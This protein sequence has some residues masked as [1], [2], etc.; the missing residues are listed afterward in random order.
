MCL[1]ERE[2]STRRPMKLG[3]KVVLAR[4]NIFKEMIGTGR[5]THLIKI[6]KLIMGL[7]LGPVEIIY[8]HIT[9]QFWVL[10]GTAG[11]IYAIFFFLCMTTIMHHQLSL[12]KDEVAMLHALWR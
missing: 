7:L 4:I 9:T 11:N 10:T 2:A 1:T 6:E 12:T 5:P 3:G 8:C